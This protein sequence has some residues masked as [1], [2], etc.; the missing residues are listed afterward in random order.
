M[1]RIPKDARILATD[2]L[3]QSLRLYCLDDAFL[4]DFFPFSADCPWIDPQIRGQV[5]KNLHKNFRRKIGHFGQ[6][7]SSIL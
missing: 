3:D 5:S 6:L 2:Q 7:A 4:D 1:P